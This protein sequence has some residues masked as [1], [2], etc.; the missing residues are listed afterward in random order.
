MRIIA[1]MVAGNVGEHAV[2]DVAGR[3]VKQVVRM[4]AACRNPRK[5][6]WKG[7]KTGGKNGGMQ[8]LK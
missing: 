6:N 2:Q 5:A 1:R 3:I 8:N 4:A 7:R